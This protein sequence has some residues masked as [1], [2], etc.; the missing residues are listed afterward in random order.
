MRGDRIAPT[1]DPA[2]PRGLRRFWE[3]FEM[4][5]TRANLTDHTQLKQRARSYVPIEVADVWEMLKEYSDATK[6]FTD[7]KRAVTALYPGAKEDRRWS[8]TDLWELTSGAL[9]RGIT[10]LEEWAPFFAQY[11][12]IVAYLISKNHCSEDEAGR[13]II[14]A[15]PANILQRV[16]NRLQ[17]KAPDHEADAAYSLTEIN[18]AVTWVLSGGGTLGVPAYAQ[19][20]PTSAPTSGAT[21]GA[22]TPFS[23]A[24]GSGAFRQAWVGL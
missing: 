8:R 16:L 13:K 2:K 21:S 22:S 24:V 15:L 17:V 23:L 4:L 7:F 12:A 10:T 5:A 18:D 11:Y 20:A 19:S 1:F 9:A 6:T 3:D 14:E